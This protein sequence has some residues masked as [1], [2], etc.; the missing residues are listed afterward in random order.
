MD[1]IYCAV[2]TDNTAKFGRSVDVW[3]R[4]YALDAEGRKFGSRV[5]S[6]FISTVSDGV[7]CER[8]ILTAAA[9]LLEPVSRES[10]MS[11][12]LADVVSVYD[13]VRLPY[14]FCAMGTE[15]FGPAIGPN[16]F[17]PDFSLI[18]EGGGAGSKPTRNDRARNRV[19]KLFDT[20]S[21][22]ITRSI[23]KNRLLNYP[24][25]MI[26]GV[27]EEMISD[28]SIVKIPYDKSQC[29]FRYELGK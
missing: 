26:D 7:R 2:F 4:L 21:G 1:Y 3:K 28:G 9:E 16:S 10:F 27:L 23:F 13:T 15:T 29:G 11:G 25:E 5:S 14:I 12:S 6:T 20:Y 22:S 18:E 24:D 8:E 17:S 19:L